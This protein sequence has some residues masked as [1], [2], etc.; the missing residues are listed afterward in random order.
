MNGRHF[1]LKPFTST[2]LSRELSVTGHI[3]LTSGM[4]AVSYTLKGPLTKLVIP[5]PADMPTRRENLWEATCLEF[6]LALQNSI[7]YWEFNLSPAGHWNIYR[8]NSYRKV[9]HAEPAFESLPFSVQRHPDALHISLEFDLT[10]IIP[11]S[12]RTVEAAI[13]AVI[14]PISGEATYWALTHPA[15]QADFHRRD[16]FM[17]ALNF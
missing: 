13:S 14:R 10:R 6:F 2:G 5:G 16:S 1:S 12:E 7:R 4:L 8:F 15:A 11:P 3:N 17:I 9:M